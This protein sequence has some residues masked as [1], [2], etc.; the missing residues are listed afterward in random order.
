M[1][2]IPSATTERGVGKRA[3]AAAKRIGLAY[4]Y[5][6]VGYGELESE[7]SGRYSGASGL[8]VQRGTR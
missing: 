2:A 5:R 6:Y 1:Q 7:M 3:M 4:E 8:A